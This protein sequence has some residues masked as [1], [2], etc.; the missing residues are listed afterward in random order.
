MYRV[1]E[2]CTVKTAAAPSEELGTPPHWIEPDQ[3]NGLA[4][5][6]APD[7]VPLFVRPDSGVST[8]TFG[9][10]VVVAL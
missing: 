6:P 10:P 9:V 4:M 2:D 7:T 8:V 5:V 1:P 3:T